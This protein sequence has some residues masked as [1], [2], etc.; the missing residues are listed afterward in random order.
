[1]ATAIDDIRERL[2]RIAVDPSKIDALAALLYDI[3]HGRVKIFKS[4]DQ[5]DVVHDAA[6]SIDLDGNAP[7]VGRMGERTIANARVVALNIPS[8]KRKSNHTT[9][10]NDGLNLHAKSSRGRAITT[11]RGQYKHL[12][13]S[14]GGLVDPGT[15]DLDLAGLSLPLNH[16]GKKISTKVHKAAPEALSIK[17]KHRATNTADDASS[18]HA[19]PRGVRASA[20]LP[21][22]SKHSS[23]ASNRPSSDNIVRRSTATHRSTVQDVSDYIA[24]VRN[25][26]SGKRKG[27]DGPFGEGNTLQAP[28]KRRMAM[29]EESFKGSQ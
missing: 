18:L 3:R 25:S 6:E 19:R 20:A 10:T 22:K 14:S 21:S 24:A 8:T 11:I 12:H 4:P 29:K 17:R 26:R 23:S 15:F 13:D 7:R 1:M 27:E 16:V 5:D 9:A 2:S 28:M